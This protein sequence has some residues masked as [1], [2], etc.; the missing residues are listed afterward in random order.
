MSVEK[1]SGR[2]FG[3]RVLLLQYVDRIS[4]P[5]KLGTDSINISVKHLP[6]K[7]HVQT[8]H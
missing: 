4:F 6:A 5:I 8:V 1:V 2:Y 3:R 7:F